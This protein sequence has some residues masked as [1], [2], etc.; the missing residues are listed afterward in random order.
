[1]MD[2]PGDGRARISTKR[3]YYSAGREFIGVG[4]QPDVFVSKTV[5]DH[6]EGRDPV[7]AAAVALA[8]A[9]K[10]AGKSSR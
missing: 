5:E 8:K 7:L 1:M 10:S 3:D 9:G 2:M 6:R 4:V